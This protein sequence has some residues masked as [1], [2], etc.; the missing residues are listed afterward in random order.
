LDCALS[1]PNPDCSPAGDSQLSDSQ[2]RTIFAELTVSGKAETENF[3]SLKRLLFS[4]S[5]PLE[6]EVLHEPLTHSLDFGRKYSIEEPPA[7]RMD[8]SG[9][10]ESVMDRANETVIWFEPRQD[11]EIVCIR[12]LQ[13]R[14]IC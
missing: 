13:E 12:A 2:R 9:K 6:K 14:R 3:L 11:C 1:S 5:R 10:C 7:S 8:F 4:M